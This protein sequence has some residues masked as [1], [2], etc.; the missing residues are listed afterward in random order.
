M[1]YIDSAV[2]YSPKPE[3]P[4]RRAIIKTNIND[5]S[6]VETWVNK[7]AIVFLASLL[8]VFIYSIKNRKMFD[9]IMQ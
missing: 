3:V 7:D 1:K 8:A 4:R 2:E 6:G 5:A 9:G